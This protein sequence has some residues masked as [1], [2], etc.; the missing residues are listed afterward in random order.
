M[1][2]LHKSP[3]PSNLKIDTNNLL[4]GQMNNTPTNSG[5]KDK[6][7]GLQRSPTMSAV[8]KMNSLKM[9]MKRTRIKNEEKVSRQLS[10]RDYALKGW[11]KNNV[12]YLFIIILVY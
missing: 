11:L 4:P 5:K 8:T 3:E 9:G 1:F 7:M 6:K 2:F 10:A 12:F